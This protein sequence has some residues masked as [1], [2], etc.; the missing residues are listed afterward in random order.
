MLEAFGEDSVMV[1]AVPAQLRR[2][3]DELDVGDLVQ[4]VLPWLRVRASAGGQTS[5]ADAIEALSA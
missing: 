2:C 1:R 3:V 4:R 5:D